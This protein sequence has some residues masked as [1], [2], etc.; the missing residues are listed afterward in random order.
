MLEA[1]R[2]GVEKEHGESFMRAR[3][4]LSAV[5]L[6]TNIFR[7]GLFENPYLDPEKTKSIVGQSS[8]MRA[9]YDAQLKSMVLLKNKNNVYCPWPGIKPC[10]SLK[11]SH[12]PE[13]GFL[14]DSIMEK[15]DYPVNIKIVEK[16]FRVTDN[17]EEADYALVFITSPN[18]GGGYSAGDVKKGGSGYVPVSLQYREYTAAE[19]RETSIAG[20][21]PLESFTNRGY[22]NKSS[23]AI[24][25]S[26]LGMVLDTYSKMK[27]KPVIVSILINNPTVF[28][29]FEKQSDVLLANFGVQDQ[30]IL[31]VL[32][33]V[34]E[35]SGLLPMQM[36]ANMET[37]EKQ[38]EDVPHDMEPYKDETGAVYDFGYGR[39][40]K[41]IIMDERVKKYKK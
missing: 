34:A 25:I 31:D 17:P 29:E 23:T 2:M 24:N 3:F 41:G 22:K 33:G 18:S 40:W 16:Y 11:N 12:R 28:S 21:D 10:I 32:T 36:P 38:K 13:E 5:R 37:V 8:F 9:G 7:T 14:G 6:L 27:G 26:D 15:L 20:G 1:Y 39:N 4:E 19:A 30:A 35:P